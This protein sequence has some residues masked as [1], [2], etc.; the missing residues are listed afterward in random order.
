MA[1]EHLV[2]RQLSA[3]ADQKQFQ[4]PAQDEEGTRMG[5]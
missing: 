1:R 4:L 3:D 2:C 5:L